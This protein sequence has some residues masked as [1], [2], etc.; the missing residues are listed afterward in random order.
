M[1]VISSLYICFPRL[2][3]TYFLP[4]RTFSLNEKHKDKKWKNKSVYVC[5]GTY[6]ALFPKFIF[7]LYFHVGQIHCQMEFEGLVY[8][9]HRQKWGLA[10][11]GWEYRELCNWWGGR[12]EQ[13]KQ[14]R[15]IW[16]GHKETHRDKPKL[17]GLSKASS[18]P[19]IHIS[20]EMTYLNYPLA[21]PPRHFL[22]FNEH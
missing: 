3:I 2:A 12:W 15:H 5:P 18:L 19:I 11:I 16:Q 14:Q 8:D 9:S 4:F 10:E 21:N 1:L 7:F 17:Q 13:K 20:Y 6:K 22:A